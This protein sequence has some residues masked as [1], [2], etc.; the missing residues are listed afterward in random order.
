MRRLSGED[1]AM[2]VLMTILLVVVIRFSALVVDVGAMHAEARQLQNVA[3]A[4]ALAIA[5]DCAA[6]NCGNAA[7][8]AQVYAAG[9]SL[10][11]LSDT[12][13]AI[14]GVSG[15]S[16]V[17]VTASTR[18]AA[19]GNDGATNTLRWALAQAMG[20]SELTFQR[21]ATASWGV[22]GG[23]A[24]TIP[25][26]FSMCEWN[27]LLTGDPNGSP[28]PDTDLPSA[29]LTVYHHTQTQSDVNDCSGPAG[30][31]V[32]GGFGWLD[33]A[34]SGT[35]SAS[36]DD[37]GWVGGDTGSGSPTPAATTGCTDAFFASLLGKVV[38]M[39][40]FGPADGAAS[41]DTGIVGTGS[42]AQ[43]YIRGYAAL[44]ITGY[45]FGGGSPVSSP[46]PCT[47]PSRC[48]RGYF[49]AFYTLDNVPTGV[50]A[51]TDYGTYTVGLTG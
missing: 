34:G 36:V 13:V 48:I 22:L 44:R 42:N 18:D 6:G 7:T 24:A 14:P 43:Y 10:D 50:G 37:Q 41:T 25:L 20:K 16:S 47:N 32:A 1:G 35:C 29:E 39:P 17:T 8:T 38:L 12:A 23:P 28:D 40:I 30:Q 19:G 9:N 21:S 45:R 26:T 33:E 4:G 49:E 15:A 27:K 46:A 5:Q 2:A 51:G 31:N 11:A 3:D